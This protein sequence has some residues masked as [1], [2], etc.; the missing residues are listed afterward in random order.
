MRNMEPIDEV[1]LATTELLNRP[2]THSVDAVRI[3]LALG[4]PKDRREE[5]RRLVLQLVAEGYLRVPQ[6]GPL[7]GDAP[8]LDVDVCGITPRGRQRGDEVVGLW[9]ERAT[10]STGRRGRRGGRRATIARWTV[11]LVVIIGVLIAVVGGYARR[12]LG[13][14]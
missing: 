12:W 13:L 5:V 1:L 2:E 8:I 4:W 3:C 10:R 9:L 7:P 11:V 6:G 14:P